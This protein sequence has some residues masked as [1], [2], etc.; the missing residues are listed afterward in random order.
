V[1]GS[2]DRSVSLFVSAANY[3][4]IVG[5]LMWNVSIDERVVL[6]LGCVLLVTAFWGR[7]SEAYHAGA[8]EVEH[9][10]NG[11]KR[12]SLSLEDD[13]DKLDTKKRVIF[14]IE[15]PRD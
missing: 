13:P 4:Y 6:F 7:K 1:T 10:P 8:I 2:I 5:C 15:V 14:D 11:T 9:L 3:L 12:Y